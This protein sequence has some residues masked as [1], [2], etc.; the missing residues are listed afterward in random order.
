MSNA[1]KPLNE[2]I[3]LFSNLEI[4]GGRHLTNSNEAYL[5]KHVVP[6]IKNGGKN[7]KITRPCI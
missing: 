2:C 7:N 5:T 1:K 3:R 4:N 6:A